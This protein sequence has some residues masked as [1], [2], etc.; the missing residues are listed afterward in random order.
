MLYPEE[1]VLQ[2]EDRYICLEHSDESKVP[3]LYVVSLACTTFS[4]S[5]NCH[6]EH[7]NWHRGVVWKRNAIRSTRDPDVPATC[8]RPRLPGAGCYH[9]SSF[10]HVS[11]F[12]LFQLVIKGQP[13]LVT[14]PSN[15]VTLTTR[16]PHDR[17]RCWSIWK[18]IPSIPWKLYPKLRSLSDT[19]Q[20]LGDKA[21]GSP[22]VLYAKYSRYMLVMLENRH[23]VVL[24]TPLPVYK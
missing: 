23:K 13:H 14:L 19:G 20:P 5:N 1:R 17:D 11:P 3:S 21:V 18:S 6:V 12:W 2:R 9:G 22:K 15:A 24:S 10:T 8:W 16:D 4:V 7:W